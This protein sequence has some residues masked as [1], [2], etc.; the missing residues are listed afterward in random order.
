MKKLRAIALILFVGACAFFLAYRFSQSPGPGQCGQGSPQTTDAHCNKSL[1]Q[2]VYNPGRL[3][4]LNPC[5]SV[6]GTVE[7]VRKE[8][9]H[10]WNELHP[11]TSMQPIETT[12]E[13]PDYSSS[14]P[15]Q[16]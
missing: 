10:G 15:I 14:H 2:Y 12:F 7:E 3:Q 13:S 4:V 16:K 6:T 5:I 11:V 8:A 9:D 1:W